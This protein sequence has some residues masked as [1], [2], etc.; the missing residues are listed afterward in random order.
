MNINHKTRQLYGSILL[1][2]LVILYYY[3]TRIYEGLEPA[4]QKNKDKGKSTTT[5]L[6]NPT[7]TTTIA[8]PTT[9]TR[10][11]SNPTTTTTVIKPTTTTTKSI[12]L[13]SQPVTIQTAKNATPVAPIVAT[14]ISSANQVKKI[15]QSYLDFYKSL[16]DADK[17][18]MNQIY[19][20][21]IEN[22]IKDEFPTFS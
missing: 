8:K 22:V 11:V 6:A 10:I 14:T 1:V 9:T 19:N 3:Y 13:P 2:L 17:S 21:F 15:K 4:I 7:T 5:T 16:S 12:A 18:E 20:H